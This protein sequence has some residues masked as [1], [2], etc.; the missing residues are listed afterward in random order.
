MVD[1]L[2]NTEIN[3]VRISL[4]HNTVESF[5]GATGQL[6]AVLGRVLLGERILTKECHKKPKPRIIFFFNDILVYGNTVINT[7]QMNHWMIETSKKSFLVSM[8]SLIVRK[9]WICHLEE[10]IRHLL[11]ETGRQPSM[12]HAAPWIPDKVTDICMH[13]TK[14]NFA[15]VYNLCYRQLLVEKNEEEADCRQQE[16]ICSAIPGYEPSSGD[17]SDKSDNDKADQWPVDTVL[18]LRSILV[19]FS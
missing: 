12:E 15:M 13:C 9:E 10:C 11:M 8:A 6:L 17:D 2:A 1:H 3:T 14:T 16:P 18:Y 5:F 4:N 19:I 7:L